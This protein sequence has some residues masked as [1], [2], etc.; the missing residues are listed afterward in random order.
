MSPKRITRKQMKRDEFISTVQKLVNLGILYR[1]QLALVIVAVVVVTLAVF[2]WRY[3]RHQQE[4]KASA[5]LSSAIKEFHTPI[6]Q[7]AETSSEDSAASPSFTSQEE[8]CRQVLPSFQKVIDSYPRS[9][10]A[11]QARY[12]QGVCYLLLDQYEDAVKAFQNSFKKTSDRFIKALSLMSLAHSYDAMGNYQQA[13]ELY[14]DN[15]KALSRVVPKELVLLDLGK[16]YEKSDQKNEAMAQYQRIIDEF[17]ESQYKDE[18]QDR[19]DTL[20]FSSQ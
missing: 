20:K 14:R 9:F 5:L 10:S 7:P 8:K 2:G 12:Y 19:L 4:L 3:Y 13:A 11:A 15:F 17:P 1:K 16:Y 6:T 18:A